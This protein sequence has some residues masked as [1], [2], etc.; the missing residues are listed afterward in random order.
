MKNKKTT[1]NVQGTNIAILSQNEN[2]FIC[3]TDIANKFGGDEVIPNWM[4]IKQTIE[5]LGVW[6][7]IHNPD[8]KPLDFEGF[9]NEAG[10]NNFLMSP[11]KWAKS[12]N[13][14]G[15]LS[16]AGRHNGGTYAH[17]DI[18][19]EFCSWLSPEFKLYLI[20]EFQRLKQEEAE[21]L[22]SDWDA[23]RYLTKRNYR[24]HT[25]AIKAHLIPLN[26]TEDQKRMVYANE[27]DMLNVAMFGQTARQ[28]KDNNPNAEGNMRDYATLNQ[29][30]VL[31]NLEAINSVL[32]AKGVSQGV[33][34]KEL[35]EIAIGQLKSLS[36]IGV[37]KLAGKF[38]KR[39]NS[40]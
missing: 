1:V 10:T 22:S 4:R 40:N 38:D 18:A 26:V 39:L 24:I 37:K 32:I 33:R 34:L 12:T 6:E 9:K 3:L 23:N 25:D 20:K 2:D 21:R 16:K 14:I 28:W 15:I 8:F 36:S 19:F 13:A 5:F 30:I 17:K 35:N 11:Q 7:Q 27:A 29:L 31:T